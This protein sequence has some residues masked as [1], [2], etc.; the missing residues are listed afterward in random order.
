MPTLSRVL[1]IA[2]TAELK[3]WEK[4]YENEINVW[5]KKQDQVRASLGRHVFLFGTYYPCLSL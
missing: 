4:R 2:Q 1:T 3:L 5:E